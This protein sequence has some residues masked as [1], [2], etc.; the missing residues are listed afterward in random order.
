LSN[1]PAERQ[2]TKTAGPLRPHPEN[3]RYFADRNGRAV[4]LTG[5]HTWATIQEAGPSDPPEPFNWDEWLD[6][7]TNHGHSFTRLWMWEHPKWGSW[8]AGDYYIEPLPWARRGPGL[9]RDGKPKFDLTVFEDAFFERLRSRTAACRDRGIYASVM[10][11]QGWS[12]EQKPFI[13]QGVNPWYSHPF[14]GDNNVN[15]INASSPDGEGRDWLHS[16]REPEVTQL[17]EAYVRKTIETVNDLDNVMYEIANECDGTPENVAWHYHMINFVHEVERASMPLQHPLLMTG[18]WPRRDNAALFASPAEAVSPSGWYKRGD[19][20]WDS[21]P[22][23]REDKVI[24]PDPDHIWG[25]GGS[26]SWVWKTFTRGHNPIYMDPWGYGHMEPR[27]DPDGD[28]AVRRAMGQTR[29]LADRL[30][31]GRTVPRPDLSSTG[32]VLANAGSDYVV[33]QPD[34]ERFVVDLTNAPGRFDLTWWDPVEGCT[35]DESVEGGTSVALAPPGGLP[36]CA[37]LAR[38]SA[39][40]TDRAATSP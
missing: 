4:Y 18:L 31:L 22:P 36:A 9:A 39:Q 20:S 13:P 32:Y 15:G 29:R 17:L 10:L 14:N 6:V 24:L 23:V 2:D 26:P 37:H 11:F 35:T 19:E 27:Y 40:T 16:L 3:P 7:L 5:S 21:D 1:E 25:V 8:W 34:P 30:D 28:D 33:Y 38:A 12:S